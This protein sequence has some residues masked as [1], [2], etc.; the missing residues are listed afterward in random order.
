MLVGESIKRFVFMTNN[1]SNM[2][3]YC[4][5][6]PSEL[7]EEIYGHLM[8]LASWKEQLNIFRNMVS[9]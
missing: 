4:S 7:I 6:L 3:L 1:I 8:V 9:K 2:P 5:F